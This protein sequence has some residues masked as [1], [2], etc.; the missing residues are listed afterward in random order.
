MS[1]KISISRQHQAPATT[2]ELRRLLRQAAALVAEQLDWQ[3]PAEVAL[4]LTSDSHIQ[5]LNRLYRGL[6]S[7]TDVLS[8]PQE[9][10]PLLAP[11]DQDL[12]LLLGDI[13]ISYQRASDQARQY[14]HSL[15]RELVFLFCHGLLHL[16]GYDHE[17]SPAEEEEM[18]AL[19][20]Q[21]MHQ[22]G[23]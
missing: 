19:Q 3:R 14:Q 21:V 2:V 6:D 12:P 22:L 11:A 15:Q 13:V 7:P 18:F 9:E 4:L 23:L 8:F 17:R 16:L 20:D 10:E 5:E 1:I